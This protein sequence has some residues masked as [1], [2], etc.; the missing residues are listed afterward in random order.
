LET[1]TE[2]FAD[3]EQGAEDVFGNVRALSGVMNLMGAT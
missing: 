1:L 2:A 3:N